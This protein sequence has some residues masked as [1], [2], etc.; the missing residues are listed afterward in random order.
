MKTRYIKHI[1]LYVPCFCPQEIDIPL[2]QRSLELLM[3]R[4][5]I[6]R[7]GQVDFR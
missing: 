6:N 1:F 5:D 7:D 4:L 3:S 2:S